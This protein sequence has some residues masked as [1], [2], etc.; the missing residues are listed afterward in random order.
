MATVDKSLADILVAQDGYYCDDPR[1]VKIVEY[2]NFNGGT[3]YGLVYPSDDPDRYHESE[4]VINPR[5]YWSAN[6]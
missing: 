5:L 2:T 4:Y 6:P 1:V 3:S